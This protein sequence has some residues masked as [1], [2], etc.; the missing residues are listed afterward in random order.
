MRDLSD[1]HGCGI[2]G[3]SRAVYRARRAEIALSRRLI[4]LSRRQ[5]LER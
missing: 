4:L 5:P 3:S 1:V 2:G